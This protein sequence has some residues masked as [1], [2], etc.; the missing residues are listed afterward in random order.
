MA[1]RAGAVGEAAVGSAEPLRGGDALLPGGSFL[2]GSD[3]FYP[4]E[5]P[6][7]RVEVQAFR[8]DRHPVTNAKFSRFVAAVGHVTV[9]ERP[10]DPSAY[11]EVD[12]AL[13]VPGSLVFQ[14][15]AGPVPLDDPGR[16]WSYVPGACWHR[17]EGAGSHP[18]AGRARL[19]GLRGPAFRPDPRRPSRPV[20]PAPQLSG[21]LHAPCRPRVRAD[22]RGGGPAGSLAR[23]GRHPDRRPRRDERR[24]PHDP[25][26]GDR[27]RGS[28]GGQSHRLRARGPPRRAD[29]GGRIASGPRA[30]AARLCG[31]QR[32]GDRRAL[33]ASQ[34]PQPQGRHRRRRPSRTAR[35][36][37]AAGRRRADLLGRA[38]RARQRLV[39]LGRAEVADLDGKLALERA[40]EPGR[41]A[42]RSGRAFRRARLFEADLFPRRGRWPS[43]AGPLVQPRGL[44]QPGDPGGASRH[45]RSRPL[46]SRARSGRAAKPRPSRSPGPRLG[47]DRADGGQAPRPGGTR[48]RRGPPPVR[49]RHVRHARGAAGLTAAA[50]VTGRVRAAGP[51]PRRSPGMP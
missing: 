2:M 5:R 16:W 20:A 13:L 4:E 12:P 27:L 7:R 18:A 42:A 9:A 8:I 14:P 26:G 46:R 43:Q 15:T 25:E 10:P 28:D 19:Q 1:D 3:D 17:P 39:A 40:A 6:V 31:P 47:A 38:A 35:Q 22:R 24:P 36:F 30:D 41:A 45:E 21:Q 32:R 50:P 51:L 34:G 37:R 23:H 49:P 48:D 11:P 29:W 44:R 33:S